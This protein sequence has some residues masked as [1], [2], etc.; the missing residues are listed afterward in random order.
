MPALNT[1]KKRNLE[2]LTV[3]LGLTVIYSSIFRQA[4]PDFFRA[5]PDEILENI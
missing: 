4:R 5:V 1:L 2:R 3:W